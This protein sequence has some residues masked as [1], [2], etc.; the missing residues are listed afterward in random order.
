MVA[1]GGGGG[2]SPVPRFRQS[3]NNHP[4]PHFALL[5]AGV[6]VLSF[7]FYIETYLDRDI[8]ILAFTVFLRAKF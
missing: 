2:G 5:P 4:G 1:G 6:L 8:L 7:F 3:C